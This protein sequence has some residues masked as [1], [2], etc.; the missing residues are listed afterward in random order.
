VAEQAGCG[1]GPGVT[2]VQVE[3][4]FT[5]I[6]RYYANKKGRNTC[7]NRLKY[8][9]VQEFALTGTCRDFDIKRQ[10]NISQILKYKKLALTHCFENIQQQINENIDKS[11]VCKYKSAS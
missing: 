8:E 5:N 2:R 11:V 10:R 3:L 4:A 6:C 1:G 9:I 7:Q